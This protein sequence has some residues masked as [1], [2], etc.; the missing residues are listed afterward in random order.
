MG[1][2]KGGD[3]LTDVGTNTGLTVPVVLSE[4]KTKCLLQTFILQEYYT[5][6]TYISRVIETGGMLIDM[7]P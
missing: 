6:R 1:R 4:S 7:F 2:L 5:K 3:C